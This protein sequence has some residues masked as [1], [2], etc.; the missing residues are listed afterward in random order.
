MMPSTGGAFIPSYQNFHQ[1]VS[2]SSGTTDNNRGNGSTTTGNAESG[3]PVDSSPGEGFNTEGLIE[4]FQ[5]ML[6]STNMYPHAA[7]SGVPGM[8]GT[9]SQTQNIPVGIP[10]PVTV[11]QYISPSLENLTETEPPLASYSGLPGMEG[12]GS[13]VQ[14]SIT[15]LEIMNLPQAMVL[16]QTEYGQIMNSTGSNNPE[17]LYSGFPGM[18]GTGSS[19]SQSHDGST[20]IQTFGALSSD[21]TNAGNEGHSNV[22]TYNHDFSH[23]TIQN[24]DEGSMFG[25]SS[26]GMDTVKQTNVNSWNG[27][28]PSIFSLFSCTL[29]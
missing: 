11:G 14:G 2:M 3:Q 5:K 26:Y 12:V 4:S 9:G 15:N 7:Y 28:W 22:E 16:K 21:K 18:L 23:P 10:S 29:K 6:S 25:Q 13:Q 19:V 24:T 20:R 1:N 8:L 17:T 27:D